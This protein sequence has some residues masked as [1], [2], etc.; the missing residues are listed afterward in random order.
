MRI[1]E[2]NLLLAFR[3]TSSDRLLEYEQ[4][5]EGMTKIINGRLQMVPPVFDEH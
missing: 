3:R 4:E 2:R 5:S 1:A